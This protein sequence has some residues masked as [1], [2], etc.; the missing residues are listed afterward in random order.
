MHGEQA[1]IAL[2]DD[3]MANGWKGI[4]FDR[5]ENNQAK[6]R[7]IQ[8]AVYQKA[9]KAEEMNEFYNMAAQ[10]AAESEGR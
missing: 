7:P 2:I 3:C 10:W 5:L 1:L 8:K 9:N 4:I 6:G